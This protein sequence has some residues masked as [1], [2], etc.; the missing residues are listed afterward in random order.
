MKRFACN[1]L[2]SRVVFGAGTLYPNPKPL[3][4][5]AIRQ[6]LQDAFEG[7]RPRA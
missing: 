4:R 2:P 6:L 1:S 7:A 3:D 5:A